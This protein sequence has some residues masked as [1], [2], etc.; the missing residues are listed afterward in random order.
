LC[1]PKGAKEVDL[2]HAF[3]DFLTGAE[4]AAENMEW[5]GYRAPNSGAY[6]H[7]S[8]DFRGSSVL[9]PPEELFAKCEPIGDLGDKLPLW[10]AE[11]DKVKTA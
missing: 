2:A 8:E 6:S 3:I 11:W 4:V 9:F 10:T 5:I 7:L 1:I